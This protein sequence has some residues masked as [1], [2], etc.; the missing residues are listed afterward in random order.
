MSIE[1]LKSQVQELV[2]ANWTSEEYEE[3]VSFLAEL[4]SNSSKELLREKISQLTDNTM[5]KTLCSRF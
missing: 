4:N 3:I 1:E 5:L 2:D